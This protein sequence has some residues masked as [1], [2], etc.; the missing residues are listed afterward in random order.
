VNLSIG[1][2]FGLTGT[3]Q[4]LHAALNMLA[5]LGCVPVLSAGNSYDTFYI[6]GHPSTAEKAISVACSIDNGT[7][8]TGVQVLSPASIVTSLNAVEGAITVALAQTGPVQGA[9]VYASPNTGCPSLANGGSMP[10]NIALID[11]GG[12]SCSFATKILNAQSAGAIAVVMVNNVAGPPTVMGGSSTGITIPGV[13]ISQS[14]GALIKAHLAEGVTVKLAAT[15]FMHPELTDQIADFSSRGPAAPNSMLKPEISAP[16][17]TITSVKVGG[18]TAPTDMS[19]TSM[20]SPHIAGAAGLLR[21]LHP[22]WSTEEIKAAL[23][24]TAR[25][26]RDAGQ[27]AYPESRAGAGRI[28]M[29]DAARV[30]VTAK[31]ENSGGL[32]S[33]S[34]GALVLTNTY[35]TVRNIVLTN[36]GAAAVSYS[37]AVS[38][39]VSENGVAITSL[40]N[41]VTVPG[42]ASALVPIQYTANPLLFDRTPDLT[43]SNL[44][45]GSPRQFLYETSGEVWFLNTNLSIHVPY[46]ANVRSAAALQSGLTNLTLTI[47]SNALTASI[48][49]SGFSTHPQPLVSAFNLG[50]I[51]A[52][53]LLPAPGNSTDLLAIGAAS[54]AP[55]QSQ[56]NN[57]TV[58]FAL[59]TAG[60][61]ASPT[62]VLAEF[63]F[64]IDTNADGV[65]DLRVFNNT[66]ANSAGGYSDVFEAGSGNFV[67]Q[68]INGFSASQRDTAPFNN[69]VLV[70]PMPVSVL[71]LGVG[72]SQFRYRAVTG[73]YFGLGETTPW[74]TF[75]AARPILDTT[76]FGINGKPFY[77]DGGSI[78]FKADPNAAA[79][80]GTNSPSHAGLMLL[81]HFNTAGNRLE[82]VDIKMVPRLYAPQLQGNN[83]LLSWSSASN[84][85]YSIQY[86]TNL[87]QGFVF[88][89]ATGLGASPPV[90]SFSVAN[91]SDRA[92]YYRIKQD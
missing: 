18:G 73:D 39:T 47:G 89:A 30:V 67:Y 57:S 51:S 27:N 25:L 29:D 22:D 24:N 37:V 77:A 28:Q 81:H 85:V 50:L 12:T 48:S 82:V 69:S 17:F 19:G 61:W 7:T 21:Q 78:S 76:G 80:N 38:N 53:Q 42:H 63:V 44:I 26:T 31:A 84:G 8:T 90:N 92:R 65:S 5:D 14:D 64:Q 79:A 55:Q 62:P 23:M 45:N 49:I 35:T 10:G 34:L 71:G 46:Y 88:T 3:N 11:R 20:A 2:I 43:T 59:A 32:V 54:D 6:V 91:G 41:S 60:D 9:L 4:P 86:A 58:Y 56:F 33:L 68:F 75:D 16:G 52:N 1:S 66:L 36:H 83:L 15:L 87:N 74:V 72:H 40:T 13:M 70:L